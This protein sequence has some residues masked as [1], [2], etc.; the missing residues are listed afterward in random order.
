VNVLPGHVIVTDHNSV[1]EPH[2]VG[3]LQPEFTEAQLMT[4][5]Q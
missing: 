2:T 1:R 3:F 4:K 5:R